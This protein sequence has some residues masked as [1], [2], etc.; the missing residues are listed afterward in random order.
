MG[1]IKDFKGEEGLYCGLGFGKK[2][3]WI[4]TLDLQAWMFKEFLIYAIF[5][6]NQSVTANWGFALGVELI[7]GGP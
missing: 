7:I 2:I 6:F 3:S 5:Q 1:C 4:L